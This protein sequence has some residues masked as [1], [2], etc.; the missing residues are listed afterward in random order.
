MHLPEIS[1][2]ARDTYRSLSLLK[3]QEIWEGKMNNLNPDT[4][5][6]FSVVGK[7]IPKLDAAQKAMGRAEYIQDIKNAGYALWQDPLQQICPC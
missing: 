2:G 5:R 7:R 1:V 3:Q 4:N 6:E